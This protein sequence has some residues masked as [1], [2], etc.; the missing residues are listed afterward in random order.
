MLY[1]LTAKLT[2]LGLPLA[3]LI[4]QGAELTLQGLQL[5]HGILEDHGPI[6]LLVHG[7]EKS[8]ATSTS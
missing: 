8:R 7:A 6:N 2:M 1:F 3:A 4:R 5:V